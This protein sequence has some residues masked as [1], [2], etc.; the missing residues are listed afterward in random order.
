MSGVLALVGWGGMGFLLRVDEGPLWK[1]A[2][3][4][5]VLFVIGTYWSRKP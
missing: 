5:A 3:Y 2:A 4:L 1:L